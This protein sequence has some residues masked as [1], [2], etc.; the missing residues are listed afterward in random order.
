M[1]F[2]KLLLGSA[3][4]LV[5]ALP[6]RAADPELLV[7]D[8]AGFDIEGLFAAYKE[9]NGEQ[10]TYTFFGDDDEAFQ[11]VVSGFRPDVVHPCVASLPRYKTA[12]L[13]EPWDLSKVPDFA[14]LDPGFLSNSAVKDDQGVWFL[15]TDWGKTA[16]AYNKAEVP[17]E[18]VTTIEVFADPKYA[19]RISLPD[20]NDDVWSLAFLALGITDWTTATDEQFQA[21]ADWLRKVHPNVRAYWSDPGE[22]AQLMAS[23][24]VLVA[25]S[26]P[27]PVALLKAEDFDVGYTSENK[28]GSATWYC[29]LVNIKDGPGNEEKAYDFANSFLRAEA[30]PPLFEAIGYGHA[31]LKAQEL[32]GA[33]AMAEA[34][35]GTPTTPVLFQSPVSQEMR[36]RMLEEFESIKAGF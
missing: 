20:S 2:Q 32:V 4:A 3:A 12:G 19:G 13:I 21:A 31:N 29:G 5:L 33:D 15:P 25:W 14:N 35:L 17:A 36:D 23:G 26:W 34:G 24:E 22:L 10:P 9:K 28:E 16:I 7:L 1:T 30:G 27:D 11:K 18:D 6:A 8:W